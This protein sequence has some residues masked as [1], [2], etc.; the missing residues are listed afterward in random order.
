MMTVKEPG[1]LPAIARPF[2]KWAGGKSQLL[3]ALRG[4]YPPELHLGG[5]GR[6]VEPFLGGGAVFFDVV[7]NYAVEDAHLFDI[8]EELILAYSVIKQD[9]Q[10]LINELGQMR[11]QYLQRDETAREALFYS[12]RHKYNEARN[13]MNW[14]RY[15]EKW[16]HR[17][18]QM[19]FLNKTCFNGLHRV[20]RSGFFNV[21][22]GGYKN[23]VIFDEG[24]LLAVSQLLA[25]ATLHRGPYTLCAEYV[26]D[27]TFVYFDPPYRPLSNTSS[28]TS[29][30]RDKF[31]DPQQKEL[32]G[33]FTRLASD[34]SARLILSNSD[35]KH[36]NPDDTFFDDLYAGFTITRVQAS[37][38]INSNGEGRGKITEIVVTN[39]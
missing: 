24:N 13:T 26:T 12:V 6:Y 5:I 16:I 37:R 28:F 27:D 10:A 22:F 35:P 15:S 2:L 39:Y 25:R 38:M 29:Y 34:S 17:A 8:N 21:P 3:P 4:L 7:Q 32:A 18:A 20:N 14:S 19:I 11:A 33:L 30:S 23:P 31:G 9:P 36:A 1:L